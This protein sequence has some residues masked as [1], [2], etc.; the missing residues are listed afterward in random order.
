MEDSYTSSK[1]AGVGH[2]WRHAAGLDGPRV[3]C[4]LANPLFIS[5]NRAL[6]P[7]TLAQHT[8]T[9]GLHPCQ[10]SGAVAKGSSV[11][12]ALEP[13]SPCSS[14]LQCHLPQRK[15]DAKCY[16]SDVVAFCGH[17]AEL[18]NTIRPGR[19]VEFPSSRGKSWHLKNCNRQNSPKY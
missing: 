19:K 16:C 18:Y 6:V 9:W 17:F 5:V 15:V 10:G 2:D 11:D 7:L 8:Y 13:D 14:S 4:S 3:W 12:T 1:A